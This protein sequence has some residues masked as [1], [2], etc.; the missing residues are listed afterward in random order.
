MKKSSHT[1]T[2][3]KPLP[4]QDVT[5]CHV[6]LVMKRRLASTHCPVRSNRSGNIGRFGALSKI[7]VGP[8][9]NQWSGKIMTE[10]PVTPGETGGMG[11][12]SMLSGKIAM[13]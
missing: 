9:R 4:S 11:P 10:E 13:I 1:R 7:S 6:G 3:K 2:I 8:S 5:Q 12:W